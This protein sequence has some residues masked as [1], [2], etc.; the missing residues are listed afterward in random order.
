M[1]FLSL[2]SCLL[3]PVILQAQSFELGL[4]TGFANYQGDL[5]HDQIEIGATSLSFGGLARYEIVPAV[6]IRGSLYYG[7]ISGDDAF[8]TTATRD[9]GWSFQSSLVELAVVGEFH[10]LG[11]SRYRSGGVFRSS[12]SPYFATGLAF[13]SIDSEVTVTDPAD[14]GLFPEPGT[15][16]VASSVP[17]IL[18]IRLDA[19][20]SFSL[21][22]EWGWRMAMTDYLDGV[23]KNGRANRDWYLFIGATASYVF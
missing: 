20:E 7:L 11:K 6:K 9:R 1:R 13:L 5:A 3:F 17:L 19:Y 23:S 4:F 14:A 21:G 10:P 15:T 22:F 12:V 16:S 8:G 2:L 18:G